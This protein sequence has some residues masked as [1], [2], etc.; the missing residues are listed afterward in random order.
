M[1]LLIILTIYSIT[2]NKPLTLDSGEMKGYQLSED[3]LEHIPRKYIC[4]YCHFMLR[5]PVQTP[6][7]HFYCRSCFENLKRDAVFKCKVDDEEF[8]V[9]EIFPDGC[10]KKEIQSLTVHCLHFSH[11]CG[12]EGKIT[13]LEV[14]Q[15]SVTRTGWTIRTKSKFSTEMRVALDHYFLLI[16]PQLVLISHRLK[17]ICLFFDRN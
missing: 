7:A 9:A 12:W 11:G 13:D 10:V 8:N 1:A 15:S 17:R 6:C 3:D 2:C 16:P 4:E 5:D 14:S